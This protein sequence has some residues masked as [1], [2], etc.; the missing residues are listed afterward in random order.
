MTS[1]RDL[2]VRRLRTS[3]VE[4]GLALSGEARWNQT[5]EDWGFMITQGRAIGIDEP[6]GRLVASALVLPLGSRFSWISMVLVAGSQRRQGLGTALLRRCID[7]VRD[8]GAVPGLD[9]TEIG[10]P[11]Y[12]PLGF[13]D[14]YPI[15][16]WV[17]GVT[18]SEGASDDPVRPLMQPATPDQLPAILAFD[19]PRS[20]MERGA[21]LSY[22]QSRSPGSCIAEEGG[23]V[24]GYALGRPGRNASQIGPVVADDA[25]IATALIEV[26][27]GRGGRFMLD[28]PDA[29][30]EVTRF[31]VGRGAVRERGYMRMTLGDAPELAEP[32]CVFALAGPELG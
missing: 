7:D 26:S 20:F 6:G 19:Q 23:R 31:L 9:A 13:R 21:T 3:D 11:V 25:A 10:R 4:G 16:R 17:L 15:S 12:V 32:G 27:I 1:R 8:A 22:L 24:V 14:R 30:A 29:H 28:V 5:A 2:F 18:P